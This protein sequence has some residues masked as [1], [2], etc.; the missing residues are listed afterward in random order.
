MSKTIVQKIR[1][2]LGHGVTNFIFGLLPYWLI[3][4]FFHEISDGMSITFD[5]DEVTYWNIFHKCG[6]FS[7]R[8]INMDIEDDDFLIAALEDKCR[9]YKSKSIPYDCDHTLH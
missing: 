9:Y 6:G 1:C 8:C 3:P 4:D 2:F 7:N 5:C